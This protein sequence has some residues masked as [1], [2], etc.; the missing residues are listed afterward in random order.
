MTRI[1]IVGAGAIGCYLGARL[2]ERG[3]DVTLVGHG[4]QVEAIAA[5]GLVVRDARTGVERRH[6]LRATTALAERP[7]LILL[8]VK[9]QDVATACTEIARAADGVPVVALQNG[10]R[11][12]ELAA[13]R[14]GRELVLGAVVMCAA[15]YLRPGEISVEFPGWLVLGEPFGPITARTRAI[16]RMLDAALPTYVTPH[17]ER[18][19]W[20]KLVANLNNGIAAATGLTMPE[21]ARTPIGRLISLRVMREGA[22]V[23][24]A[25]GIRLDHGLYGLSPRALRRD[26]TA[27]T[28]ALL[29]SALTPLLAAL[30]ERAALAVIA[31]AARGPAGRLPVRGSTWQSVA[32]GRPSEIAYLNGEIVSRGRDLGLPTPYNQRVVD[33]VHE[34]ERTRAFRALEALVPAHEPE[35][36]AP[37]V[38]PSEAGAV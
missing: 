14:L 29:Q 13:G 8:T 34:V 16:A 3:H 36:E 9:T 27:A 32:R 22:R 2:A 12:D 26:P 19:R 24:R 4:E 5:R 38:S 17:L 6:M 35:R 18:V 25:A 28:I 7:D 11:G 37:A 31:A 23:A 15:T 20:A 21:I 30:P 10:V 33:L 1:A